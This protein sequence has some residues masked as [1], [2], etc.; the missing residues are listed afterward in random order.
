MISMSDCQN[1]YTKVLA[2]GANCLVSA[3]R[4]EKGVASLMAGY[5]SGLWFGPCL[6]DAH[7]DH[8]QHTAVAC[9]L[10]M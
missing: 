8:I 10:C 2:K 5:A 3:T 7:A 1:F 4:K 9:L 6:K